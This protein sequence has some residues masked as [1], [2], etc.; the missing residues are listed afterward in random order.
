M[1]RLEERGCVSGVEVMV[2]ILV[3]KLLLVLLYPLEKGLRTAPPESCDRI[4]V[5]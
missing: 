3:L 4:H 1:A 2:K 5:S